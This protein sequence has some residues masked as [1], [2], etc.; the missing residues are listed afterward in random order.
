MIHGPFDGRVRGVQFAA[1]V[2]GSL[3]LGACGGGGGD[4][5]G[6]G[7]NRAPTISG[8]P[9]PQ[10]VQNRTYSFTPTASDPDGDTLT[11]SVSNLPAWASFNTATGSL[12]GT[13][14]PG[15][16]ATYSNISISVSDGSASTSLAAFSI[17]VVAT[18][19]GSATLSWTAPTTNTDGTALT[20]PGYKVY[21][22]PTPGTYPNVVTVDPGTTTYVITELTPGTWYFALRAVNQAGAESA[23]TMPVS[24]VVQ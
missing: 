10:V 22:S 9:P 20:N 12:T 3:L 18:A 1:V 7:G 14:S 19:S 11:F 23:L 4:S 13:P 5:A 16:V 2:G 24:K 21:Y 17:A 15:D 6:P 8:T